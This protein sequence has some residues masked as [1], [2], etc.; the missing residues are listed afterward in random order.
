MLFLTLSCKKRNENAPPKQEVAL[1]G[2]VE[3]R[4]LA[5]VV[6]DVR[7]GDQELFFHYH[8][9]WKRFPNNW[10]FRRDYA[11][12]FVTVFV[13]GRFKTGHLWALQNQQGYGCT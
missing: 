13:I 6:S 4:G 3:S 1:D 7:R 8:L 11:P 9:Q 2:Y 12:L 10:G 5:A